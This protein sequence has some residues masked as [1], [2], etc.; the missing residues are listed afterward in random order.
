[1]LEIAGGFGRPILVTENG[2]ADADDDQRAQYVY[3]HL[4]VLQQTVAD[5]I[6]DVRGYY[7]WSLTDNFEWSS[8]YYPKFGLAS[9]D[10][11]T[12]KRKLRKSAKTLRAIATKN[13]LTA[14]LAKRFQP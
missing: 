11:A 8:G 9:Y 1:V 3:D 6:A 14:K 13:G 4:A 10:P 5:G 12:G 7:Y 2:I